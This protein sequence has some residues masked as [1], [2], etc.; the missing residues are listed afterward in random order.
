MCY[1]GACVSAGIGLPPGPSAGLDAGGVVTFWP[2]G[3]SNIAGKSEI[4]QIRKEKHRFFQSYAKGVPCFQ[5]LP[6]A[7][8]RF[9]KL[10]VQER[11]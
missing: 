8:G 7:K 6:L 1:V 5:P 11:V 9:R 4:A 10:T 2:T 3:P